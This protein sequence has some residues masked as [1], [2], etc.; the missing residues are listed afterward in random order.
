MLKLCENK[1]AMNFERH[2]SIGELTLNFPKCL[3]YK[4]HIKFTMN[5]NIDVWLSTYN[6]VKDD[7]FFFTFSENIRTF[8]T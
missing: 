5:Y 2:S 8:T 3:G 4:P 7:H 1:C 6:F